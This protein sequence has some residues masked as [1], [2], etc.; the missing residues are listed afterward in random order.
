MG[1]RK[2]P[3]LCAWHQ[4]ERPK[5]KSQSLEPRTL[6]CLRDNHPEKPLTIG[7][8]INILCT[9]RCLYARADR[10]LSATPASRVALLSFQPPT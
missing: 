6:Y 1:A 5:L 3:V 2:S 8:A 10:Q 9:C 7:L 4:G